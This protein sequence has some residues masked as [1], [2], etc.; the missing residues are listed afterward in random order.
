V[1]KPERGN[2][3]LHEDAITQLPRQHKYLVSSE[4]VARQVESSQPRKPR[5]TQER[6]SPIVSQ[7]IVR[8]I[9]LPQLRLGESGDEGLN[10]SIPIWLLPSDSSVREQ[11]QRFRKRSRPGIII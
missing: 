11:S 7:G 10:P 6:P 2:R 9:E 4:V 8:Q 5:P 3:W 1:R